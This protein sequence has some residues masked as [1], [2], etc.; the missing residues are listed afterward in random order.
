[1]RSQLVVPSRY[2]SKLLEAAK[3][4]LHGVALGITG[5]VVGPRVS[6][7][8]ARRNHGAGAARREGGHQPVAIVATVS[9]EVGWG[10]ARKQRQRLRGIVALAGRQA[11]AQKP[12]SGI[13]YGVQFTRQPAT[14]ASESLRP[15]FLRAPLACWCARTVVESTS[16]VCK[17]SSCCTASKI[18]CQTPEVA[19][20]WK[21]V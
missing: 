5:V 2:A 16:N 3:Q 7:L 9:N 6:T 13:G 8:P 20:R 4:P 11:D 18:R 15:V 17:A 1:M 19:Q 12:A 21:R 14:T 10:Q